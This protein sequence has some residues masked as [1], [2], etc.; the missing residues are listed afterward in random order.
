VPAHQSLNLN[1]RQ[2][3]MLG[4]QEVV[5]AQEQPMQL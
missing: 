5:E 1:E 3:R 4:G 2:L